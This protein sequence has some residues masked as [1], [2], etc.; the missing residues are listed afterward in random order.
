MQNLEDK[1]VILKI[2]NGEIEYFSYIIKKYSKQVLSYVQK[3]LFDK[4][5]AEDIVQ[6]SFLSFYKAINRFDAGRPVLP[7][8]YQ[9]VRNEMKMYFRSRKETVSLDDRISIEEKEEKWSGLDIA[10]FLK[11]LPENQKKVLEWLGE[12]Y[13]Y[14][15]IAKRLRKPINTIRTTIR[16]ARLRLMKKREDEKT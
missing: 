11:S 16:R 12:G 1:E 2:Q 5:E 13:S 10:G 8:L 15:E 9:I 7:Y 4:D 6:N 3:K 14:K